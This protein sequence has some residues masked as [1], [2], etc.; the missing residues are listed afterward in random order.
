MENGISFYD[1]VFVMLVHKLLKWDFRKQCDISFGSRSDCTSPKYI[2][3]YISQN[4]ACS[5]QFE[6]R[7]SC[8]HINCC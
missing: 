8:E 6:D 7:G 5:L 1:N 3:K 4:D 2:V